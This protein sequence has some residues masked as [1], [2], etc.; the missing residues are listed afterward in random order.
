RSDERLTLTGT[1]LGDAALVEGDAAD[2][3]YIEVPHPGHAARCLANRSESLGKNFVQDLLL[4]FAAT[5]LQFLVSIT[6]DVMRGRGLR[7]VLYLTLRTLLELSKPS[8]DHLLKLRR[9]CL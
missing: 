5:L 1:H 2:H 8:P 7:N 3:L 4:G 9:L 6:S